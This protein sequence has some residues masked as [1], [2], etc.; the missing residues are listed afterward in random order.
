MQGVRGL[1]GGRA[2]VRTMPRTSPRRLLLY[3][4]CLVS[5]LL[6]AANLHHLLLLPGGLHLPPEEERGAPE[7]PLPTSPRPASSSPAPLPQKKESAGEVEVHP[8]RPWY[9][10]GGEVQPPPH[11]S[12]SPLFPEEARASD[13]ISGD[14]LFFCIIFFKW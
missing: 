4:L 9:M 11:N 2:V 8:G 1:R 10:V 7:V 6:L 5:G 12:S 3:L 13:R 14:F